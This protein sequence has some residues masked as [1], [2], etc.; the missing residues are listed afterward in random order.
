VASTNRIFISFPLKDADLRDQL[1]DEIKKIN[2]QWECIYMP[3]KKSWE[4]AWKAECQETVS[5][6]DGAIGIIT[7]N[8]ARADGQ[9][10]ELRCAYEGQMRV[11]LIGDDEVR[12]LPTK[13][14]PEVIM[15][16]DISPWDISTIKI[17]LN[18]L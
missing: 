17:F 5:S 3:E 7:A 1:I 2:E 14:L 4:S 15:N 11:L 18:R 9:Q 6:C 16:E 8:T 13:K 10:W 12:D